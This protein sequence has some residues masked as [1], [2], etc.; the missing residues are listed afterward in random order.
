M[1]T[2]K[3]TIKDVCKMTGLSLGTV[4]KYLNGGR[5]KEENQKKVDY[6]V[7]E[8]GYQVDEYARGFITNRTKTVGVLLPEF[9]NMFYMRI[10]SNLELEFTRHGYAVTVRE[11]HRNADRERESIRWFAARRIDVLVIVPCGRTAQDY[12]YLKEY[13]LPIVFLDHYIPGLNCEFVLVDNRAVCR[14]ALGYLLDNGHRDIAIVG[15]PKGI[16]TSDERMRGC[17]EAFEERGLKMDE[18]LC[19]RVEEDVDSAYRSI[20][21]ILQEKRCT[22]L[23]TSSFPNTYGAIFAVNEL[24]LSIPSELSLIGFDDMMFTRVFR[25][26]L[27]IV[28][29][30][31]EKIAQTTV[32]RIFELLQNEDYEYQVTELECD[33]IINDSTAPCLKE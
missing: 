24:R 13:D 14:K 28:D 18:S 19:Y 11:S 2:R 1:G 17:A 7:R 16:Y 22:A 10:V 32:T 26:K 9:D 5:L 15:A 21:K 3:V 6:A 27:T 4:S 30:P 29:Q 25:P 8:L 12:E 33:L 23:F 31:I 20:K